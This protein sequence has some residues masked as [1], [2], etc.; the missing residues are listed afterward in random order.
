[1]ILIDNTIVSDD[2]YHIKFACDCLQCNG[3]CCIEGDSGA[4]LEKEEIPL[5]EDNYEKYKPYMTGRGVKV[6]EKNGHAV[7]DDDGD[8]VTHLINGNECAYAFRENGIYKCAIEKAYFEGKVSFRK[9]VS[10]HLYPVRL[11]TLKNGE[12]AVNYQKWH[13]CKSALT[14]GKSQRKRLHE[15]LKEPLISRFGE[16][17]YNVLV[18]S[19]NYL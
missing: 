6:I 14:N 10:C 7:V 12:I 1:M 2:L 4:P 18:E 3:Q 17:W 9:P 15:F 19:F 5:L 16:E 13:I 8:Y 11:K